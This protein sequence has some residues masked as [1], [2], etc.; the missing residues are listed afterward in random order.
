[1]ASKIQ[2]ASA[3]AAVGFKVDKKDLDKLQKQLTNLKKQILSLKNAVKLD[4]NPNVAGLT[5]ARKELQGINRELSKVKN[6]T[7]K[8][9]VA[10]SGARNIGNRSHLGAGVG[11]GVGASMASR[12]KPRNKS[13]V[14]QVFAGSSIGTQVSQFGPGVGALG[15]GAYSAAAI[16]KTTVRVEA[17]QNALT[18]VSGSV[19][20]GKRQFEFLQKTTDR[21]GVEFLSSADAY[22]G[23]LAAGTA[24]GFSLENSENLF[25]AVA[26]S[27]RVLGLSSADTAGSLRAVQQM[28]QKNKVSSEE[29]RQQLAERLPFAFEAMERATAKLLGK[30]KLARGE[31]D[32][33]LEQGQLMA[34]D[35]LPHFSEE[36]LKLASANGGLAKATESTLA[37]MARMQNAWTRLKLEIG[38]SGFIEE[39]T[40]LFITLTESMNEGEGFAT[41]FGAALEIVVGV[42]RD[43]WYLLSH[44][45]TELWVLLGIFMLYTYPILAIG[46][47]ITTVILLISDLVQALTGVDD[48]FFGA[49]WDAMQG[50]PAILGNLLTKIM[51]SLTEFITKWSIKLAVKLF[52][53]LKNI[54]E[55]IRGW[56]GDLFGNIGIDIYNNIVDSIKGSLNFFKRGFKGAKDLWDRS[57]EDG[58]AGG[59]TGL[60]NTASDVWDW[61]SSSGDKGGKETNV[62]ITVSSKE[63]LIQADAAVDAGG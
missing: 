62:N 18:A 61:F 28:L 5:A 40:N 7:I 59:I 6:K 43:L 36:L 3:F 15:M 11:A 57:A 34:K 2:I 1:M 54:G 22:K 52:D 23:L 25:T 51:D 20:G 37:Q 21:L 63:P 30:E 32:K 46:A 14:G 12:P 16:Y 50:L 17:L 44:I 31:L 60:Q 49:L 56:F 48:T 27:A 42:I 29:L 10:D 33:M 26:S 55:T 24:S 53:G 45:P 8:V 38:S 19:E 39:V 35:V 47:A 13:V 9:K 58:S 41:V 4:I